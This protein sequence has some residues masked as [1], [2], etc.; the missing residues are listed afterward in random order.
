MREEEKGIISSG[1]SLAGKD[2][3]GAEVYVSYKTIYFR[4]NLRKSSLA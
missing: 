1:S 2:T 4:S 3:E